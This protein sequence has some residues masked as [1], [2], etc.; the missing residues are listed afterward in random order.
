M[1]PMVPP[2]KSGTLH[3]SKIE[4]CSSK[5]RA[6][7]NAGPTGSWKPALMEE[8]DDKPATYDVADYPSGDGA[9]VQDIGVPMPKS[10]ETPDKRLNGN[11]SCDNPEVEAG[12]TV[13]PVEAK[14]TSNNAGATPP[15]V[16]DAL[17]HE[18]FV[19]G[20]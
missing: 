17:L 10:Y 13:V 3:G 4:S 16:G 8:A 14:R 1:W 9:H 19:S 12:C 15:A 7:S 6:S 2:C 18:D 5:K 11:N 20:S